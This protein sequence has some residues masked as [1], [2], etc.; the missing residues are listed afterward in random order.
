MG[1]MRDVFEFVQYCFAFELRTR[2]EIEEKTFISNIKK[3][4]C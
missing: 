3:N 4:F 2:T 1:D